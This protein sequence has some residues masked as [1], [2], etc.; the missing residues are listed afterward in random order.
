M[1]YQFQSNPGQLSYKPALFTDAIKIL[2]SVN[3]GIFLLQTIA[4]TESLFFPLFGLVPKL[5]WSEFMLWQ[6][7]TYL[8]F[9]GG[10]WHVLINMFVLW[11]FGSELERLW[12]KEYFL[13][14]YFGTGVGAG[15]VTLLFGLNSMT[16]IVGASGAVYGVLLAYGLTYPNRTI[17]LYGLIPIKSIWFVIGIGTIAFMSSFNTISQISHM[18]HLSGMIIGYLMLKRPVHFNDLW[19]SIRKRTM[20]YKVQHEE[21]KVS[22]HKAIEQDIDR[23][24]DKINREGFDSLTDEEHDRLYKGSQSLSKT[25]KKD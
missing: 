19:F 9:H 21:K 4:R 6:P 20:E 11:M 16:P 17:Y 22:H 10:V 24:L 7:F 2:V 13:K 3:F 8:F 15:L 14:F 5:V 25:K 12:G 23:I 18:T 1:R